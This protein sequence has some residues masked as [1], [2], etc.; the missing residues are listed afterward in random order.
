MKQTF[1]A[2]TNMK[3]FLQQAW[4]KSGFEEPTAIQEKAL[5]VILE[6]RDLI[7]ESPTGTGKTL[8]YLLP[9]L[10][11]IDSS[12][13]N[14]QAVILASSRELVMQIAEEIRVWG[15][16]GG[17]TAASFIGGANVKRQ[18]EKLK[19]QPQVVAGTPGRI[20]ELIKMKKLKMHEVKFIVLDEGDQ[21]LVPENMKDVEAIVKSTMKDRQLALFSA[22]LPAETERLAKELMKDPVVTKV[23]KE[24]I[25]SANVDHIYF[26]A[27]RRDKIKVLERIMRG[28][29]PERALAFISDIGNVEVFAAKLDFNGFQAGLLHSELKK[30]DRVNALKKFRSGEYPLLLA[31][32]VA[33]RGLDIKGLT[34]V[35][36]FDLAEDATQYTHRAGRTGR[37]GAEGTVISIVTEREERKLK[38]LAKQ[39]DISLEKK[40]FYKGKVVDFR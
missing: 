24:E 35:I 37:A 33:A 1:P 18:L 34:H 28:M 14:V 27:E 13:K 4:E 40:D 12:K 10:E 20:Q 39:L 32:D 11:R 22:T 7:A 6:G 17:I 3:P 16:E 8:A 29:E 19:K 36:H 21:L 15:G 38:Q 31:T 30:L 25:K 5:P 2:L 23:G 26:V 9:L